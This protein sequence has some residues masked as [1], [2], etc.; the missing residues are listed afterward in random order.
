MINIPAFKEYEMS[1]DTVDKL[2][3][4]LDS[5]NLPDVSDNTYLDNAYQTPNILHVDERID[6]IIDDIVKNLNNDIGLISTPFHV[7]YIKYGDSG[8]LGWHRHDHNE[9][10]GVVLYLTDAEGVTL[11]SLN[12]K[13][14]VTVSVSP[15]K[16]KMIVF[17]ATFNHLGMES[18]NKKV[19][20]I[21]IRLDKDMKV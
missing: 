5:L 17:S 13:R 18:K 10:L 15:K 9:E 3:G 14:D 12:D 8:S 20:V 4:Y 11:F 2:T 16:G 1:L 7:H 6:K 19:F 21:G